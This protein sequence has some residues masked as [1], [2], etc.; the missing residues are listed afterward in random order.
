MELISFAVFGL[1][2]VV[3]PGADFVLVFKNSAIFG[4]KA[5]ILTALGI[6]IGVCVHITYSVI[7]ISHL[8]SQN[9]VLF[10]IVKYI[11]AAYLIYLGVTG[12]VSSKLKLDYENSTDQPTHAR[13]Y[14][15]QG[16]LCNVLNPKTML[17]FLSV[18]SQLISANNE[19]MSF[20]ISYGVYIALLHMAWFCI[21]AYLVTSVHASHIIKKF[22]HR[23]NQACG[24]GL[25]AFGATLSIKA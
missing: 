4:R 9:A 19:G 3:S 16:F 12:L 18:F 14:I 24:L 5:G 13:K 1:L 20:V 10:S 2:I 23:I 22:G 15:F 6:G 11:G 25:I 8:V 7:G 17:F 21:V